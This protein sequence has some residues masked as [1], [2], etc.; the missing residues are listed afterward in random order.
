MLS[1]IKT[2]STM[3]LNVIV[4]VDSP[5]LEYFVKTYI[6]KRFGVHSDFVVAPDTAKRVNSAKVDSLV[7]P[8]F[9]GKWMINIDADKLSK[10]DIIKA[11]N[12]NTSHCVTVYWVSKYAVYKWLSELD[13]LKTQ[14]SYTTKLYLGKLDYFDVIFLHDTMLGGYKG[15]DKTLLTHVAKTY[16]YDVQAVCDLF[17]LVKS[18]NEVNTKQEIAELVGVGG[19]SV[20]SFTVSLLRSEPSG[21]KTRCISK[22][23]RLLTDLSHTYK[24]STIKNYM[25][26][27]IDGFIEMK[28]LQIMGYY[29]RQNKNIPDF[30]D[31]KKIT[32]L[33][34]FEVVILDEVSMPKLLNLKLCLVGFNSFIAETALV[35][36]VIMFIES[37]GSGEG[38]SDSKTKVRR[39]GRSRVKRRS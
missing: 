16:N 34:R 36:A 25:L 5:S 18:G 3:T 7:E 32:R 23:L 21:V 37:L 30:F 19:N 24:Y 8:L 39:G 1:Y 22:H 28:Q 35:Q 33:K 11:L 10:P 26:T 6:K 17:T 15:L 13:I 27:T 38:K 14:G 31:T 9:G 29:S 20:D 4:Y 12:F 2:L